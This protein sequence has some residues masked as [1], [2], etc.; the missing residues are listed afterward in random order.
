MSA[1]KQDNTLT[2]WREKWLKILLPNG[3]LVALFSGSNEPL[4]A[5]LDESMENKPLPVTSVAGYLFESDSYLAFHSGMDSLLKPLGIEYFRMF[6]CNNASDQFAGRSDSECLAVEKS[7]IKL[8]RSHAILGV[9]V[10][11]SEATYKLMSPVA[12][13]EETTYNPLCQWCMWEV[14][15]WADRNSFNG[16]VAY[17]FESGHRDQEWTDRNLKKI[18]IDEFIKQKCRYRSHTFIGK[19]KEYGL[20][21]ADLLAWCQRREGEFHESIRVGGPAVERRKDCQS[22]IGFTEQEL[23]TIEHRVKH[24]GPEEL[25]AHFADNSFP[26]ARWYT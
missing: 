6:E 16:E 22:L 11:V 25:K 9:S 8:I 10:S 12:H 3:G 7:V 14:G 4:V 18:E 21:A 24:L 13:E 20:Q 17:F 15:K 1:R 5:Y 23:K 2:S 26:Q 19:K